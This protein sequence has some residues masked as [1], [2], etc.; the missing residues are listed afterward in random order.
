MQ[1][2]Y[3]F[4]IFLLF[5]DIGLVDTPGYR[6]IPSDKHSNF[7]PFVPTAEDMEQK[8]KWVAEQTLVS[9][10]ALKLVDFY[11]TGM[12]EG[13][14]RLTSGHLK[15]KRE[16]EFTEEKKTNPPLGVLEI[17]ARAFSCDFYFDYTKDLLRFETDDNFRKRVFVKNNEVTLFYDGAVAYK[18][19]PTSE[20]PNIWAI[21]FDARNIG[22]LYGSGFY[23]HDKVKVIEDS[24]K[25]FK[26]PSIRI[27]DVRTLNNT[28]LQVTSFTES[29][30]SRYP[31]VVEWTRQID[32]SKG[33]SICKIQGCERSF[34]DG[35][36]KQ[37]MTQD[38]SFDY[39][40]FGPKNDRVW[41]PV[42]WVEQYYNGGKLE[43]T[44]TMT[45]QW[46]H[47]N[48][49]I[50]DKHFTLEGMNVTDGVFMIDKRLGEGN[51]IIEGEIIGGKVQLRGEAAQRAMMEKANTPAARWWFFV[52]MTTFI[53]GIVLVLIALYRM[54]QNAR[55]GG[56][57]S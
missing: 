28:I 50:D 17:Q 51:S 55:K 47:V 3:S 42:K 39:K 25:R 2:F 40:E 43:R 13:R 14:N 15:L 56:D 21:P 18:N 41:L 36:E 8:T 9:E 57:H 48:E 20:S 53:L 22:L 1:N 52:R 27:I 5:V 7:V 29:A 49:P 12:F 30:Q 38:M 24:K 23:S 10:D 19:T 37:D 35:K 32:S 34:I 44:T 46:S 45:L 6:L 16:S 54:T 4:L 11:W 26:S 33:F 31:R